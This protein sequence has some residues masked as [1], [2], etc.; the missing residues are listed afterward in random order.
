MTAETITADRAAIG[1]NLPPLK[2]QLAL[3]HGDI[4]ER[5]KE[6]EAAAARAP[7]T[8]SD[9]AV[10][11]KVGDLYKLFAAV[12][13]RAE[14]ARTEEK[15]PFL[16]GGREVDSWFKAALDP[17]MTW[18]STL[19]KRSDIYINAK[20]AEERRRREEEAR[21]AQEEADRRLEAARK[22]EEE[23]RKK[24]AETKLAAAVVAQ[25]QADQA[26]AAAA[27]RPQEMVQTRGDHSLATVQMVWSHEVED[28]DTLDLNQLR[29]FIGR[30]DVDKAIRAFVRLHKGT[31]NLKGVRIFEAPKT[32]FR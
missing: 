17:V 30:D 25:E 10:Q 16:M 23:N 3:R 26:A 28:W 13:K 4:V 9:D 15:E 8:I 2:D 11:G 7:S 29:D 18:M 27:A 19:K 31:R 24:S 5:I 1:S 12:Q 21:K 20:L 14:A 22:A 32:Q 6:L